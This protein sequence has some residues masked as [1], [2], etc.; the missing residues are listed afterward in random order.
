MYL[1]LVKN[2]KF[3]LD[4]SWW[5]FEVAFKYLNP[6]CKSIVIYETYE[7]NPILFQNANGSH[8]HPMMSAIEPSGHS[9][10]EKAKPIRCVYVGKLCQ[11]PGIALKLSAVDFANSI[12]TKNLDAYFFIEIF[13][14]T[15]ITQFVVVACFLNIFTLFVS[16][17]CVAKERVVICLF[18]NVEYR[19]YNYNI[20][21][22]RL[23]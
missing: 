10:R 4:V 12:K 16:N 22:T 1:Y 3:L 13:F 15:I 18:N 2:P 6:S 17:L 8:S 19:S 14:F 9:I 20:H 7:Q 23:I 11:T 21:K 5:N